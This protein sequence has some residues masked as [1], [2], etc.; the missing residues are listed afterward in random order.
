MKRK[1]QKAIENHDTILVRSLLLD[2]LK[3]KPGSIETLNSVRQAMA[4][5]PDIFDEDNGKEYPSASENWTAGMCSTLADDLNGNFSR[6][7]LNLYAEACVDRHLDKKSVRTDKGDASDDMIIEVVEVEETVEAE[8]SLE[9]SFNA[10][11]ETDKSIDTEEKADTVDS[12][13]KDSKRSFGK[14]MAYILI[15]CGIVASIVGVCIPVKFLI[16]LGIGVI[17]VGA[18]ACYSALSRP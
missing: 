1:L 13:S 4:E 18:A 10:L 12:D 6:E 5:M 17:M 14:M 8:E 16:G 11:A 2:M 7:K 15:A 9:P 3:R